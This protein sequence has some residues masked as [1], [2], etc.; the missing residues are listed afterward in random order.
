MRRMVLAVVMM[1]M[2]LAA[3][4]EMFVGAHG[5]YIIERFGGAHQAIGTTETAA[6]MA[7]AALGGTVADPATGYVM[8]RLSDA[9]AWRPTDAAKFTKRW[10][11][12]AHNGYGTYSNVSSDGKYCLAYEVT[13]DRSFLIELEPAVRLVRALD[14]IGISSNARWRRDAGAEHKIVFDGHFDTQN[15]MKQIDA[16]T[17]PAKLDKEMLAA[18]LLAV[19]PGGH[20][21][22]DSH[23]DQS[24]QYRACF[25]SGSTQ[26][27]SFAAKRFV[28]GRSPAWGHDVSPSGKW[29]VYHEDNSLCFV[30]YDTQT[31]TVR[32]PLPISNAAKGAGH[33]GWCVD[34]NGR[35]CIYFMDN[36]TDGMRLFCPETNSFR[37]IFG[38]SAIGYNYHGGR[39]IAP[40]WMFVSTYGMSSDAGKWFYMQFFMVRIADGLIWRIGSSH[41]MYGA[42]EHAENCASVSPDGKWVYFG[43]NAFG[44]AAID[45]WR[46]RLPEGWQEDLAKVPL[47]GTSGPVVT[48]T[49]TPTPQPTVTP[50]PT[51][52]P[53][54]DL[55]TGTWTVDLHI[56]GTIK[57]TN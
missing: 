48:P 18:E 57:R 36:G 43:S 49:P 41:E 44:T 50:A 55:S 31:S 12:G 29:W 45:L 26:L 6:Q 21:N 19:Q 8:Q 11:F 17:L 46:V 24:A 28:G 2:G 52:E 15:W 51:P 7:A 22:M 39:T 1:A 14:Y 47:G 32:L 54:P 9:V 35:E 4:G 10:Q 56:T 37:V 25:T 5:K 34:E 23:A 13:S 40:G 53:E 38:T 20:I 3:R 33:L 30:L 27:Y 16:D 42:W